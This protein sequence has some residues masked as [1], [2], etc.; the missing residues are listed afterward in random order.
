[1]ETT[2]VTAEPGVPF[3]DISRVFD[4]P[5]DLVFRAHTDPEL[6][7]QWLGGDKYDMIVDRYDVRDG[8]TWR[9]V[10]R[11]GD[12][13]EWGFH[14]VFHGEPTRDG[15]V[16][17]FEFEGAPGYVSLDALTL[18][19]VEHGRTRVRIHSVHQ[20]IEGRDAM[21]AAGMATGLSAGYR[22]LDELIARLV[23]VA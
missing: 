10:H 13:N 2:S 21:V 7:V 9:Y 15:M 22:R 4:A 6:L 23:P 12:G 16:Q 8:G 1:M 18:E 19:D 5:R 11:D 20:S 17:T 3:I 14:G